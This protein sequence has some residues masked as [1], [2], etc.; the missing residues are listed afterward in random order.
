LDRAFGAFCAVRCVV[1]EVVGFGHGL[2][3]VWGL[4]RRAVD[5]RATLRRLGLQLKGGLTMDLGAMVCG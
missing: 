2:G 3:V 4:F 1:S 5:F